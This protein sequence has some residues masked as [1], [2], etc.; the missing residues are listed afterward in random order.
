M[1]LTNA[2][3]SVEN[4][5]PRARAIRVLKG[6]IHQGTLRP[7][8]PLPPERDL[9]NRLGTSQT[10]VQ[11]AL[12]VLEAEGIVSPLTGRTRLVAADGTRATASLITQ[13]LVIISPLLETISGHNMSGWLEYITLGAI[14]AARQT[15]RHIIT[16]D[17][18]RA[19][20]EWRHGRLSGQPYGVLITAE[21]QAR[22]E[23]QPVIQAFTAAKVPV[24]VYGDSPENGTFDRVTADHA[25]GCAQLTQWLIQ[26]GRRRILPVWPEPRDLYWK[27]QRRQGYEQAMRQAGLEPLPT[28]WIPS[29]VVGLTTK[30]MGFQAFAHTLAGYLIP[31]LTGP[32][33]VDALLAASDGNSVPLIA[34]CRL[35]GRQPDREVL[36]AGYDH[37]SADIPERAF[38]PAGPAV[39]I[40]KGNWQIGQAL[41]ELLAQRV[42]GTLPPEPQCRLIAPRLVVPAEMPADTPM[43]DTG[44]TLEE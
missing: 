17:P 23:L 36:I 2:P 29:T 30:Q 13:G 38:E 32:E 7:G 21:N 28:L 10:T 15:G 31:Y 19:L 27:V 20:E 43:P 4:E 24:V 40:D 26:Q 22:T 37:Y 8:M 1:P 18:R 39:T 9:C 41:V 12:R 6:W 44:P 35:F 16:L 42:Q 5:A 33:P 34:A 14:A 11:R 25:A 3:L